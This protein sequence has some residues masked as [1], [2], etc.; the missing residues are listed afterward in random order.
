MP[1]P[2]MGPPMCNFAS[3]AFSDQRS[4]R[5]RACPCGMGPHHHVCGINAGDEGLTSRCAR[6]LGVEVWSGDDADER[7]SSRSGV[8]EAEEPCGEA[9]ETQGSDGGRSST[10]AEGR[11]ERPRAERRARLVSLRGGTQCIVPEGVDSDADDEEVL[12]R[13]A[14]AHVDDWVYAEHYEDDDDL[15]AEGEGAGELVTG[16]L[17]RSEEEPVTQG[18]NRVRSESPM[19]V[20]PMDNANHY[21]LFVHNARRIMDCIVQYL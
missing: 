6:C 2:Q 20:S 9:V 11:A 4:E 5:L 8:A 13:T 10:A 14:E 7:G 12:R 18:D 1:S 16:R 15:G 3:C 21:S 19:E 17:S